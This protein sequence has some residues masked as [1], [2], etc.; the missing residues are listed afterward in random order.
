[1]ADND[2]GKRPRKGEAEKKIK[3][4]D[5]EDEVSASSRST[6]VHKACLS[7]IQKMNNT[8]RRVVGMLLVLWYTVLL[9]VFIRRLMPVT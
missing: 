1:M 6:P 5:D 3:S 4:E 7:R 9:I 8:Q 2:E